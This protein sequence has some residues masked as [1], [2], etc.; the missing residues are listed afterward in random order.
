MLTPEEYRLINK[1]LDAIA[2]DYVDDTN[3][4]YAAVEHIVAARQSEAL[5]AAA[6]DPAL[7]LRGHAG[8]SVTA[9]RQ[10]ARNLRPEEAT[11]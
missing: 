3:G 6:T 9:L 11:R 8:V 10:R 2:C 1:A 5:D 4:I 7:R